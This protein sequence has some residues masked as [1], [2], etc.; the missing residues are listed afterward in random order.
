MFDFDDAYD[1]S[2]SSIEKESN[3]SIVHKSTLSSLH[4]NQFASQGSWGVN[5]H[6][7][8]KK[9]ALQATIDRIRQNTSLLRLRDKNEY[10]EWSLDTNAQFQQ[11]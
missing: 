7:L 10:V 9:R 11:W 8:E 1:S 5:Q 6:F 4:F 3:S 2:T